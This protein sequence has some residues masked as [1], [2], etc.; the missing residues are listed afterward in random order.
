M[1]LYLKI[2][3]PRDTDGKD[4]INLAPKHSAE[5]VEQIVFLPSNGNPN[6][7]LISQFLSKRHPDMLLPTD[8]AHDYYKYD[9]GHDSDP[10][11][12]FG[13][14]LDEGTCSRQL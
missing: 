11:M 8:E 7:D 1:Q 12:Y 13:P 14:T 4:E 10:T 9:D 6:S 2:G 5:E 3:A